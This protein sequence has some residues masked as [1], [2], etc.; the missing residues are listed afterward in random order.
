MSQIHIKNFLALVI[1]K[2]W[3]YTVLVETHDKLRHQ[4]TTCT[5]CLI[6]CQYYWKGMNK[7]SGNTLKLHLLSQIKSKSQSL[8]TTDDG[9][10]R[11]PI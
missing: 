1:P 7:E 10:P 5:Y 11:M 9:D 8:P 6:K 4:G 3:R 2:A